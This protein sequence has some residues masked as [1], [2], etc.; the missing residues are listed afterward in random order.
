MAVL[1]DLVERASGGTGRVAFIEGEPGI[2]KTRL[3]QE[4]VAHADANGFEAVQGSAEEL[5]SELAFAPLIGALGLDPSSPDEARRQVGEIIS[6][7]SRQRAGE[8]GVR[9]RVIDSMVELLEGWSRRN[10]LLLAIE[11]LHWADPSTL[12]ALEAMTRRLKDLPFVLITTLRPLPSPSPVHR[13]VDAAVAHGALRIELGPLNNDAVAELAAQA[14]GAPP[15]P[16]LVR[17]LAGAGGNPL[18]VTEL[19][20]ALIQDGAIREVDGRAEAGAAAL[21]P[22]LQLVILHQ[23][24]PLSGEVLDV[25]RVASVLGSPFPL[26]E[27]CAVLDRKA[28]DLM[29]V[30]SAALSARVLAEAGDRLAFRHELVREALYLDLP[31]A[32]RT[33][34]HRQAGDALVAAGAPATVVARHL[35]HG[36]DRADD[37]AFLWLVR[38]ARES[39]LAPEVAV[40]LYEQ[41]LEVAPAVGVEADV[42]RAAAELMEAQLWSGRLV[43]TRDRAHELLGRFHDPRIGHRLRLALIRAL[44]IAGRFEDAGAEVHTAREVLDLTAEDQASLDAEAACLQVFSGNLDGGRALAEASQARAERTRSEQVLPLVDLA[45]GLTDFFG[46]HIN[47]AIAHMGRAVARQ[48]TPSVAHESYAPRVFLGTALIEADQLEEA[49]R[50]LLEGQKIDDLGLAWQAAIYHDQL[51]LQRFAAGRWDEAVA[52]LQ[53][54]VTVSD[55]RSGGFGSVFAHSLQA[56]IAV[57]R[58]DLMSAEAHLGLVGKEIGAG[59]RLGVDFAGWATALWHEARGEPAEALAAL[60]AVWLP[61][62]AIGFLTP[63]VRLGSD[64]TRLAVAA[65]RPELARSVTETMQAAAAL[66]PAASWQ[67]AALLCRGLAYDDPSALIRAAGAYRESPRLLERASA[68]HQVGAAVATSGDRDGIGLVEEAIDAYEEVDAQGD[69]ARAEATLRGLG[70]RRG[71]RGRRGRPSTG[72]ESLT[73]TERRVV[74][75]IEQGLTNPEI[76]RRLFISHRTVETHVSHIFAKLGISSRVQL[77]AQAARRPGQAPSPQEASEQRRPNRPGQTE[78]AAARANPRTQS[79]GPP[80]AGPLR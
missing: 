51:G 38:A 30:L 68:M 9:F 32:T 16:G 15:G 29:T 47:E 64:L 54:G 21:P 24:S 7:T 23:L 44:S 11:D 25:L 2:G 66:N 65:E 76:G 28:S 14:A 70:L 48:H 33:A 6:A 57:H 52:E 12:L 35:V 77:A 22:S 80:R 1:S 55:E 62:Q 78:S 73:D 69:V 79:P 20:G 18:F 13:M 34:L 10:P 5:W 42:D 46:G 49:E 71:R 37:A 36:G 74:D 26:S 19:V 59:A 63:C 27:L 3:L 4:L 50:V 61:L 43:E 8:A 31:K 72:W 75:L 17:A 60:E 53:A 41:A 56:V 40:D 45:F 67:G 58:D 39:A